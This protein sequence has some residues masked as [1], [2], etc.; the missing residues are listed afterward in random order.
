[1]F[2]ADSMHWLDEIDFHERTPRATASEYVLYA[3]FKQ[4]PRQR[5][6]K[7][8]GVQCYE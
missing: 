3:N 7:K 4:K 1:M 8:N 6:G 5:Y 2:V